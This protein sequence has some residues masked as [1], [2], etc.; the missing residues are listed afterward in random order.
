M[1]PSPVRALK[2]KKY[3]DNPSPFKERARATYRLNPSLKRIRSTVAYR[4]DHEGIKYKRRQTYKLYR[5]NLID[6]RSLDKLLACAISKKY[7]KLPDNF[8]KYSSNMIRNITRSKFT[9]N[10]LETEHL[11]KSCMYFRGTNHKK[12]ISAF[13]K[14]KLSALATLS[15]LHETSEDP[16]EILLGPS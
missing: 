4:N 6:K 12:F 2:R 10:Y 5:Q 16:V 1:D 9:P 11:V 14:L 8:K 7:K 13:R 3:Q 15:K